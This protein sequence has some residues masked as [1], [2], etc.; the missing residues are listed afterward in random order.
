[1]TNSQKTDGKQ[2]DGK[3]ATGNSI[4]KKFPPGSSGNPNGRPKL[5]RLSEAIRE[6]LSEV[7][8]GASEQT[9]AEGIAETL[10]KLA[11]SGDVQAIREIADRTEGKPKQAIDLDLDLQL[12]WRIEAQKFGLTKN[13]IL[14]ETKLLIAGLDFSDGDEASN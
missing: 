3:F 5:T 14:N 7:M 13:D 2:A 11:L 1:M 8:P 12:D 6:Q 4:G 10:I 9:I